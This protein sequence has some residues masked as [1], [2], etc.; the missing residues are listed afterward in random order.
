MKEGDWENALK[1]ARRA[2]LRRPHT[3][4]VLTTLFD[5]QTRSGLWTEAL[6]TV[7]DMA[8]HKLI[9]RQTATRWRRLVPSAGRGAARRRP[10]YDALSLARKAHKLQP[11]FAPIAVQTGALAEQAN[12]PSLARKVLQ[13]AWRAKPHPALAKAYL[14]LDG[15]VP[16]S[17][18]LKAIERLHQ[19]KPDD[20]ESELALAEQAIAAK[21]W[22]ARAALERARKGPTARV[23][24]LLAEVAQAEG[25]GDQARAW[26]AQAVDAPGPRLAVR[27]HRT[28]ARPLVGVRPR[29]PI[30]TALGRA[31][32]DRAP[33][34]RDCGADPGRA[35]STRPRRTPR[36]PPSAKPRSTPPDAGRSPAT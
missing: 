11:D 34:R 9:D 24:R 26:L 25:D 12:Q 35:A 33:G 8:K 20:L 18:R 23:Y 14:G 22:P 32:Q 28:G 27:D 1:L 3:P 19:L 15:Q 10:P 13:R 36:R 29:R 16:A 31:A 5:L 4:W 2:Y 17:E 21:A 7:R 6:S 30:D